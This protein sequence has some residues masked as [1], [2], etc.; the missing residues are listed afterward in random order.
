MEENSFTA[1]VNK[2]N[3][4]E[5]AKYLKDKLAFEHLSCLWAVDLLSH[6]E[7][8]YHLFSYTKKYHLFLKTE[9]PRENAE[10]PSVIFLWG[11]ADWQEREAFEMF[12]IKFNGHPNLKRILLAEDFPGHP[13][14][15]DY[16][17][18]NDEKYLLKDKDK[19]VL[20]G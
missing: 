12:G 10:L 4:F 18:V 16:P 17:M 11:T 19:G 14:R 1:R 13:M 7:V 3:L 5:V 20:H 2:E 8:N 15:K 6:L 9:L